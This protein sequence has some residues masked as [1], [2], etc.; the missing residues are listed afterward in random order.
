MMT[1]NEW[2]YRL[3]YTEIPENFNMEHDVNSKL[4][5]PNHLKNLPL[6]VYCY[7]SLEVTGMYNFNKKEI[8]VRRLD[9]PGS[10]FHELSHYFDLD[11]EKHA[12]KLTTLDFITRIVH[13]TCPF[14]ARGEVVAETSNILTLLH[15]KQPVLNKQWQ[16]IAGWARACRIFRSVEDS[17]W[18]RSQRASQHLIEWYEKFNQ[19]A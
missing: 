13:G 8:R 14:Y 12:N 2:L 18:E 1:K 19:D 16:Y 15:L 7:P 10:L 4:L 11:V 5:T 6:P 3:M 9:C 17:V